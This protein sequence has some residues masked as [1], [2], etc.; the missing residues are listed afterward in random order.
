MESKHQSMCTFST[1]LTRSFI[2]LL[3]K[4]ILRLKKAHCSDRKKSNSHTLIHSCF[5]IFEQAV[6]YGIIAVTFALQP[7]MKWACDRLK[8][9]WRIAVADVFLFLSFVGTVNVWRGLWTIL[10]HHFLPSKYNDSIRKS[11]LIFRRMHSS[12]NI[13][14]FYFA[15]SPPHTFQMSR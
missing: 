9:V 12:K 7:L 14:S 13:F 4:M 2:H 1:S 10:D 8:G 15:F 5:V 3:S 11:D 6:G